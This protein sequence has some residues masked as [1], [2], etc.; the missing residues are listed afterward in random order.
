MPDSGNPADAT[1]GAARQVILR[2]D[3]GFQ[4]HL[5]DHGARLTALS[6]PDRD[7]RPADIVLGHD[8]P[9]DYR[10]DHGYL[11]ATCGRFANRIAGGQ[12]ALD[13]HRVTLDQNEGANHLHGGSR[14][15]DKAVWSTTEASDR[16][17]TFALRSPAGDMG[18]PGRVEAICTYRLDGLRLWIEMT[19]TTDTPTVI[20]MAH[21]SYFNLAGQGAGDILGH[22]LQLDA[23]AYLPVD[24]AKL[25]LPA[26]EPVLGTAFDFTGPRP[27]GQTL[28]GPDGFDHC[29][30]LTAPL[31]RVDGLRP[32]ARLTDRGSGRCLRLWTD[33]PGLQVYT[34]AH[35]AGTPGKSGARYGR[36]AGVALETQ[37]YPDSPNRPDFPTTTLRPGETYRH[38]MLFDFTPA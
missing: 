29:F 21:H 11:G 17:V 16:S 3:H 12:F 6:V 31:Q 15:W 25:P 37:H 38:R 4:A 27:I 10:T 13:G 1:T 8:H 14:G 2:G 22:E 19:A 32:T 23:T 18:F 33:Q 5:L 7:G 36:F 35:F 24:A 9:E 28:P 34:G 30:C 26:P 20:N